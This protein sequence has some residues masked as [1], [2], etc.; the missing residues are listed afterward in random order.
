[1]AL[2]R[3]PRLEIE[4]LDDFDART[5]RSVKMAGWTVQSVDLTERGAVLAR[6]AVD[7]ALF[8]GCDFAP[9][10]EETLTERGAY[11]FPTLPGPPFNPYRVGLY[12]ADELYDDRLY[13]RTTDARIDAWYNAQPTPLPPAAGLAMSLHDNSILEALADQVGPGHR[14]VGIMG[15]HATVRGRDDYRLAASL[16]A[17]LAAAGF[18]VATGGGPG[19]MEA[20]NLG[21]RL[22]PADLPAAIDHLARVPSFR[23]SV[24]DWVDAARAVLPGLT[25][26]PSLGIPT[27]YYG[28]EPPNVF[29][30]GIAKLFSNAIREDLLLSTCRAGL[31]YLPGAAGTVQEVFQAATRDY[32]APDPDLVTPLILVGR[33]YWTTIL[34][35]W[36]L[37]QALSRGRAMAER[38]WLVDNVD[39]ALAR[40]AG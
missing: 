8:L 33:D 40:L 9:G 25:H 4:S 1:M 7:G 15:G 18:T 16:G 29:A 20:A 3:I 35:A 5:S 32:Y 2:R 12:T 6:L 24:T 30:T 39:Q 10:V 21:A 27:W 28:H 22:A 37:I 34:P 13:A 14:V 11:V 17:G 38:I 36:G 31:V 19:S 23:P 26:G